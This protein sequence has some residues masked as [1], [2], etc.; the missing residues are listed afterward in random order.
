MPVKLYSCAIIGFNA[1]IIDVEIETSYGLR[2]FDIVGLGDKA[3]DESKQRVN[4][5]I[6]NSGFKSPASQPQKVLVN[7]APADIKKEGS[8]F[9]LPIALGYLLK[10]SQIAFDPKKRIFAGELSLD[11]AIKPI[12]GALAIALG[13]KEWDVSEL[14]VPWENAREAS[15][16]LLNGQSN[17]KII[18]AKNLLEIIGHL[19]GRKIIDPCLANKEDLKNIFEPQIDIGWI[20]GQEFAK[21]AME[22]CAA[23]GHN[24][25]MVGPPGGGKSLLAKALPSIL[26]EMEIE[27]MIEV[28]KIYSVAGLLKQNDFLM[29][30]RPFRSPH[31]SA[32][33]S[34]VIGGGNPIAPGEIT[35]AHRGVLF[36][37]EFPEF[38]RD[39][40]E[41]LRQPLEDGEITVSRAKN[42]VNFP[43]RFMLVAAANPTP[44]GFFEDQEGI[45][46]APAQVA[47]YKRKLSGPLIDRIDI[48][49][50]LP[51]VKYDKL[52][53]ESCERQSHLFRER[54]NAARKIQRQ[55]FSGA[56][57]LTNAEMQLPQIKQFCQIDASS[58]ELL[59]KYVDNGKLSARGFHKVL[60]VAR[61]IADL[62]NSQKI[63]PAHVSEA[64]MYRVK[65]C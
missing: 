64:L 59:K 33:V 25:L 13:A 12:K 32:S 36:M 9:D 41:S 2:A 18:P 27:E 3:V 26:P 10:S 37:D 39:V 5:A 24:L 49:I 42:R 45:K 31:H 15:L 58:G 46:Y 62:E 8:L 6:K 16:A 55:R 60:K 19:S 43:S 53:E 34:A 4:A 61:T 23:G 17:L 51:S 7:L 11:G 54:I 50:E 1:Q 14:I 65:N 20:K 21:R 48:S 29:A 47:K 56:R 22:V 35:L 28:T 30:R 40:L 44:G 52:M 63:S 57:I 38:H